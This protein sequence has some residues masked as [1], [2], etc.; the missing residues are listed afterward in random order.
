[1]YV[2]VGDSI[3]QRFVQRAFP[4]EILAAERPVR[5]AHVNAVA[6]RVEYLAAHHAIVAA[7]FGQSNSRGPRVSHAAQLQQAPWAYIKST[8]AGRKN[9]GKLILG[10][11]AASHTAPVSVAAWPACRRRKIPIGR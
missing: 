3:G 6:A 5:H 4:A 2:T 7:P 1:M 8:A 10:P 11:H 9:S